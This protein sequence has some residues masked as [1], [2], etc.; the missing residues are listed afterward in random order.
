MISKQPYF[1][2]KQPYITQKQPYI[3]PKQLYITRKQPYIV[4]KA[5][6]TAL[7]NISPTLFFALLPVHV[8]HQSR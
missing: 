8:P 7:Y 2:P 5:S 1:T 3:T 4:Q 6:V